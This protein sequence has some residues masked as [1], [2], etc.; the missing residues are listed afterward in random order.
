MSNEKMNDVFEQF[1][2]R[3]VNDC[4]LDRYEYVD[5]GSHFVL[6]GFFTDIFKELGEVI[7]IV[8]YEDKAVLKNFLDFLYS[9]GNICNSSASKYSK[10]C[11]ERYHRLFTM[12]NNQLSYIESTN[13]TQSLIPQKNIKTPKLSDFNKPSI[14]KKQ[15]MALMH[16]FKKFKLVNK[17]LTDTALSDCFGTLTGYVGTQL[18]KD[19]SEFNKDEVLFK[20]D[21]ISALKHILIQMHKDLDS[22]PLK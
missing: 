22:L 1:K 21:E 18:R 8:N 17:D 12:V 6:D 4:G 11:S 5:S 15:I 14:N 16:L 13:E 10:K 9:Q 19:F 7:T 20:S 2:K 3:L